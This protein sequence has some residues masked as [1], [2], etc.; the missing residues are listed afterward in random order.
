MPL[1]FASLSYSIVLLA[2]LLL[3]RSYT[4]IKRA[5]SLSGVLNVVAVFTQSNLARDLKILGLRRRRPREKDE[6]Q[7]IINEYSAK[8]AE[9]G[10]R[11]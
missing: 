7:D 4:S 2:Q 6:L 9:A 8:P 11:Q 3:E 1:I 5:R 10:A